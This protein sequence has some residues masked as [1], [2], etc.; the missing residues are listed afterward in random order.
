MRLLRQEVHS[1][2]LRRD[3]G[4]IARALWRVLAWSLGGAGAGVAAYMIGGVAGAVVPART[5]AFPPEP[6]SVEVLLIAGPIH[7]DFLLP[8]TPETRAAFGFAEWAGVRVAAPDTEWLVVGWGAQ[9]FYTTVGTYWDLSPRALWRAIAGDSA[10]LRISSVGALPPELPYRRLSLSR[11]Q[12]D[13]LLAAIRDSV[14]EGPGGPVFLQLAEG[15]GAFYRAEGPFNLFRTCNVWVAERL[16]AAG[17][18]IGRWTP[19]PYSVT[20]SLRWFGSASG[21]L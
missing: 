8:A 6:P 13:A 17:V 18:P 7:Y 20:L 4:L 19:A 3:G 12:Y 1:R 9:A 5:A 14:P 11:S 16:A 21:P 15:G 10:V 2:R